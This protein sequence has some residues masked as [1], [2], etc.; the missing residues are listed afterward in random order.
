MPPFNTDTPLDSLRTHFIHVI[1]TTQESV[2]GQVMFS[3]KSLLTA[4]AFCHL[5]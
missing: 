3:I 1:Y 4:T 2:M 5:F